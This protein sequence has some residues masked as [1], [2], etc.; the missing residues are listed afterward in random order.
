MLLKDTMETKI[1]RLGGSFLL[2][3]SY[4]VCVSVCVYM[5]EQ[6]FAL[7]QVSCFVR[8][9]VCV[10]MRVSAEGLLFTLFQRPRCPV[11]KSNFSIRLLLIQMLPAKLTP[12][13]VC[14]IYLVLMI[15]CIT[16]VTNN[17]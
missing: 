12:C 5:T 2:V 15:S 14:F 3:I 8:S 13:E 16:I 9:H 6:W 17:P 1:Y 11:D 4:Y 10:V 7:R